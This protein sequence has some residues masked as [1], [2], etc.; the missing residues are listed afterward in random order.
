MNSSWINILE[1]KYKRYAIRNLMNILVCGM[2]VVYVLDTLAAPLFSS[3]GGISAFLDFNRQNVLRG[4][5]WRLI[6][7]AFMPPSSGTMMVVLTLY[8]YWIIGSALNNY[9]GSFR[10]NLFY[11][12]GILSSIIGG[13]ITGYTTN[14]YLNMSLFF[15]FAILYPDFQMRLFFVFPIKIKYLALINALQYIIGF[16]SVPFPFK[17]AMIL[18]LANIAL[19]FYKDLYGRMKRLYRRI[20]FMHD[21]RS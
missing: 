4:Q 12:C 14:Y 13:F 9:W 7:F 10:F 15:A 20:R 2:A 18:S 1:K 19:F 17:M 21:Y 6:T 16:F 5:V 8:L 11:F 3:P